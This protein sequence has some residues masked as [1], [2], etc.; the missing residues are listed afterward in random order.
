MYSSGSSDKIFILTFDYRG[1]GKSTGSPSESGILNDAK[2]IIEWAL[3]TA[4]IP[5]ERIVL[6]GHSL[7]T[8]VATGIAHQYH[9]LP[10]PIEFGG[11]ILCASFTNTGSAF[12][13]Y[14]ILNV[15]PLL[16][17]IKLIPSLNAWFGRRMKD[18]WR[19]DNRLVS[20]V[21]RC[22]KLQLVLVHAEDDMTMPWDQT[23]E[24]FKRAIRA[25][26]EGSPSDEEI[27]KRLKVID[28]GEAGRQEVWNS[29]G[30]SISKLIAKHGG[31][32][33]LW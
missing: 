4:N 10:D 23:E 18:T 27:D 17:P 26:T 7:G 28:L 19:T 25:A 29:S 30:T 5:P 6:L 11:L 31:E 1:F 20:L 3:H 13:S 14:S 16:A 33:Y 12:S 21:Q 9:N 32:N 22:R 15:F 2:A 8:A 24:L